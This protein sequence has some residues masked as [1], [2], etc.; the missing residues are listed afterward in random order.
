MILP[1]V[2]YGDPV[3]RAPAQDIFADYPGLEQ[4]VDDMFETMYNAQ[5]IG[6]AA[7]QVGHSIRLFVIDTSQVKQTKEQLE[8]DPLKEVFINPKRLTEDG[9]PVDY[10]E[11]CLSVPGIR[12]DVT[13]PEHIT[14][15][16]LDRTWTK[17]R[18]TF[19]GLNARVIQHEY[20]HIEGI[21]FTDR[22]KPL[23][24]RFLRKK[25]SLITRGEVEVPYKM[26]F[27]AQASRA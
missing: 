1:V 21:L 4:L 13:R 8:L 12:E 15:E 16:Y 11:G 25:L 17:R 26:R 20:D 6:L 27:P 10:E 3:L 2:A 9:D 14:L 5:G 19:T 7:P 24:K 22:L 23:K 18:S